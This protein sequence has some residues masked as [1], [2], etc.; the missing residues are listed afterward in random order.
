MPRSA[1]VKSP[2]GFYHVLVQQ[3]KEIRVFEHKEERKLYQRLLAQA[4]TRGGVV[5][6]AYCVMDTHAHMVLYD[7][8]GK[9][10]DYMRYVDGRFHALSVKNHPEWKGKKLL[11][12]R[13]RS[14]PLDDEEAIIRCIRCLYRE[15]V[16]KG[17]CRSVRL[18][19]DSSYPLRLPGRKLMEDC[20][21]YAGGVQH[22][23]NEDT[24]W[25][26]QLLEEQSERYGMPREEAF[27][28]MEEEAGKRTMDQVQ[29]L[30]E[31]QRRNLAARM[32][33]KL[34]VSTRMI[35]EFTGLSRGVVQRL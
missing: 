20:L 18:Y 21:R 35:C 2:S 4:S 33:K 23:L 25:E 13:F 34:P 29:R 24:A 3:S 14:Q 12:D 32:K 5:L 28:R 19:P 11:R 30:P 7:E 26:G 9:L 16:E 6:Y 27:Q 31:E 1:R 22:F 10:S 17:L 8:K 15:P